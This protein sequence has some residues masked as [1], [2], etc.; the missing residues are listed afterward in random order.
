VFV[1]NNGPYQNPDGTLNP[2]AVGFSLTGVN[3][4][5][6]K[7]TE[8]GGALRT[9][10]AVYAVASAANIVG[11]DSFTL[12][13]YYQEQIPVSA[14]QGTQISQTTGYYGGITWTHE[15]TPDTA[16]N[17]GVQI[18]RTEYGSQPS[19][20]G[21]YASAA[22]F[23]RINEKL[24]GVVRFIYSTQTSDVA[25]SEYSQSI[26]LAGLRQTF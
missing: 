12:S 18:G 6:V 7:M 15:F 17:L 9:W 21:I 22:V 5:V 2:N 3:F 10:E 24:T 11:I 26:I 25:A 14:A 19:T 13:A 8:V 23:H 20:G 4:V 16:M 1:G